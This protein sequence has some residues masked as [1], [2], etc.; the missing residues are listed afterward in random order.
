MSD[1]PTFSLRTPLGT[2][3][4]RKF[5]TDEAYTISEN[6]GICSHLGI[7]N[8]SIGYS[9]PQIWTAALAVQRR[10]QF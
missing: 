7:G 8:F 9:E 5:R 1:S 4:S 10:I 2:A 6:V 3:S